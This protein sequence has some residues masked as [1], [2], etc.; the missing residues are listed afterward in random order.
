[1]IDSHEK[2]NMYP[3]FRAT[4]LKIPLNDQQHFG[5]NKINKIKNS[6]VAEIKGRELMSKRLKYIASFGYFD[7]S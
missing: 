3:N 1:M 5:L 6:F 4:P 7:K 2:H